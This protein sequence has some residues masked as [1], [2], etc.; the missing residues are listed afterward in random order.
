MDFDFGSL[1]AVLK[2]SNVLAFSMDHFYGDTAGPR[3][4]LQGVLHNIPALLEHI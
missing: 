2:K 3:V 4:L 1:Q